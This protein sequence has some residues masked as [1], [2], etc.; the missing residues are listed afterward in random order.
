MNKLVPEPK[1]LSYDPVHFIRAH[2][3][4]DDPADNQT[5]VRLF[6]ELNDRGILALVHAEGALTLRICYNMIWYLVR[7][8]NSGLGQNYEHSLYLNHYNLTLSNDARVS[9]IPDN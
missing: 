1:S 6:N 3:K 8:E 7:D 5:Q 2:S 4:R 9:N